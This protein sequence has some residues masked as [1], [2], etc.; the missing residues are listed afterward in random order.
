VQVASIENK[1]AQFV[2]RYPLIGRV[3]ALASDLNAPI[4]LVGGTVRDLLLARD[5]HDL[6]FA[7]AGDGLTLARY[8]ADRLGGAY[9]PLD[10]ER[11]TGRVVLGRDEDGP[12][13]DESQ[14]E[15]LHTTYLDVAS[16]RGA[17][18]ATDLRGRDFTINAMAV[19]RSADGGW[20]LRDVLG[21]RQD[22][23][24]GVLRLASPSSLVHDPVRMLRAV[25]LQ[26]QFGCRMEP[27]TRTRLAQTASLLGQV[28]AERIRDE[29]FNILQQ[30]GAADAVLELRQLGL[31]QII[32][33]PL[34]DL[35]SAG[36]DSTVQ[37]DGL[38]PALA[39][40]CAIEQLWSAF[41]SSGFNSQS[42]L[43]ETLYMLAPN[44][45]SRY[46]AHICDE[47]TYLALLKSAALLHNVGPTPAKS[48]E[49]AT[50]LGR[51]WRCSNREVDLLSAAIQYRARAGQL[52]R[53]RCLD[54]RSIYCYYRDAG[55]Y[56][57]DAAMLC[58]ADP[59]AR[60]TNLAPDS[61]A[62]H[63]ITLAKLLAAYLKHQAEW[64]DP[65]PLLSG[66]DLIQSLQLAPGPQIGEILAGLREEQA[67]GTI[68]TR[69][70]ALEWA[71]RWA[72]R[73]P[74]NHIQQVCIS[75]RNQRA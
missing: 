22:L 74:L 62:Q 25:R 15:K 35:D 67:A 50:Q 8:L 10:H 75:T 6:D 65:L 56:G 19:A 59:L 38:S 44:I 55:E 64:I 54:R 23:K 7:T 27:H 21:G 48:A 37:R 49:V 31:L 32:A 12:T 34:V 51:R 16:L 41:Q 72:N 36:Q 68:Q 5:T 46:G 70:A 69:E 73:R 4:Y 63:A 18:L 52:A 2:E 47:R 58:L 26:A 60:E 33:P 43:P 45:Q 30:P 40:V 66:Q 11:R 17:D 1:I 71:Q 29:W 42:F 61:W 3:F 24:A 57:I 9:V 20:E 14:A 53:E 39:C 28:S 13:G